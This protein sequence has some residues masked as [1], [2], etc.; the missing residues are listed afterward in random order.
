[1]IR[2]LSEII[3]YVKDM[4][5]QVNFYRDIM[6][7]PIEYPTGIDSYKDEYWVVFDT[8][9]CKLALHGGGEGK[10]GKDSP[11]FVFDVEDVKA[12][13]ELLSLKGLQVGAIRSP[14]PGVEVLDAEDPEGNAFSVEHRST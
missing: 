1:M 5:S 14:T 7:L 6:E 9:L 8:G 2:N 3:L 11:K 13:R 4:E 10:I 12:M